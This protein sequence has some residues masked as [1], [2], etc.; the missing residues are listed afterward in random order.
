MAQPTTIL[1]VS[2]ST[3][4]NL[5]CQKFHR[6]AEF[7]GDV[8]GVHWDSLLY[9]KVM[10]QR[11]ELLGK[12]RKA[13]ILINRFFIGQER[14]IMFIL[15]TSASPVADVINLTGLC[16]AEAYR[17][18]NY[19]RRTIAEIFSYF[20]KRTYREAERQLKKILTP[21]MFSAFH[22]YVVGRNGALTA[23]LLGKN[24][25]T[26]WRILE[27]TIAAV[28]KGRVEHNKAMVD[29]YVVLRRVSK[30]RRTYYGAGRR[31]RVAD[32]DMLNEEEVLK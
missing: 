22:F 24:Q 20:E 9:E 25:H 11:R 17:K 16:K 3:L 26:V 12:I 27:R 32:L 14:D 10:R 28:K 6:T 8:T 30:I 1:T 21:I 31:D 15:M 2:T 13:K 4:D 29:L 18:I 23:S 19:L 7:W 5:Y